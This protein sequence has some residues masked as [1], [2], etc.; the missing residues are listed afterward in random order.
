M[1]TL[2]L[3]NRLTQTELAMWQDLGECL[4]EQEI[5]LRVL[6]ARAPEALSTELEIQERP[7]L[8]Q[9]WRCDWEVRHLNWLEERKPHLLHVL[10]PEVAD[11]G[12][13]IAEYLEIPYLLSLDDF[14]PEGASLRL[15]KR[16]FRG[17][18]A[19]GADLA[20][21]LLASTSLPAAW[22]EVL[23]PGIML[24]G[25]ELHRESRRGRDGIVVVGI[26]PDDLP[27]MDDFFAASSRLLKR[28]FD[29][30]FVVAGPVD[31]ESQLRRMCHG[32]G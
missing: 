26:H 28:G 15:S 7:G 8:S 19:G 12:L 25:P 24:P 10:D 4:S 18:L 11:A 5:S 1:N 23:P 3:A 32:V 16:W 22:V 17:I 27:G 14:L 2:L 30:E 13:S 21:D 31:E 6:C 29:A 20:R 9:R